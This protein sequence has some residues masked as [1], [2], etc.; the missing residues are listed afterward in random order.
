MAVQVKPEN[1]EHV[2]REALQRA[3]Q[4]QHGALQHPPRHPIICG[5]IA[6]PSLDVKGE[7]VVHDLALRE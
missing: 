7:L 5:I 3:L 4:A 1:L 6:Y 2:A